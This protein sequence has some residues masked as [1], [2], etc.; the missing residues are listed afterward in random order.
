MISSLN[1]RVSWK[2]V[3]PQDCVWKNLYR[4]I[5][6][7]VLQERVTIHCNITVWYTNLFLGLKPW[8]YPQQRQQWIKNGL[9]WRKFRRGTWQKSEVRKRWLMQQG[10]RAQKFILPHWRTSVIERMPNW[11]QSTKNTKVELYS[12]ATLW[13]MILDL[14]QYLQNKDHQHHKWRQQKSWISYPDCQGA[15]DKQLTQYLL[16]PRSKWKMLQNYWKCPNRNVQILWIRLPKHKWPKSWSSME[17]PVVPLERNLYGHHLAEL[18]WEMQFEKILLKF[19]WD[20]VKDCSNLCMWM[21]SNWLERNKILIRCGKYST[22]KLIWENQ[23][24]SLIIFLGMYSKTM[25]NKQRYCGQLQNHVRIANFR[26]WSRETTIPSKSSYFFMVLWHGGSCK[27]MCLAIL[28]VGN[29]DDSATLQSIYTMHRWP[30]LQ[31]RRNEICWRIV[32]S[33]ISHCSEMLVLGTNW[34][35]WYSMVSE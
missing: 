12:E 16:K 30:P 17:D 4:I 23:H 13:K 31:R 10:R 25:P 5:M 22:K 6:R 15:Q 24:H 19:G 29:Q 32:T 21:T 28:W 33:I 9:N 35:T 18:L 20:K 27:E 7:T 2:P 34:K 8:R 1:L 3:N 11:R 26:G 14:M